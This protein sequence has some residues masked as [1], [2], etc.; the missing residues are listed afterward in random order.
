MNK[1]LKKGWPFFVDIVRDGIALYEA[2]ANRLS[3][4]S[5]SPA[6]A[7]KEAE[8]HSSQWYESAG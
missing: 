2:P 8:E 3:V 4:R 5:P 1:R 7:L 6:E